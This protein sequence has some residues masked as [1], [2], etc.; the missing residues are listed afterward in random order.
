[1]PPKVET[2]LKHAFAGYEWKV[3]GQ[4]QVNGVEVYD[5]SV[6]NQFGQSTAAVTKHGDFL[7]SGV[8]N[9]PSRMAG[10]VKNAF[11]RLFKTPPTDVDRYTVTHYLVDLDTGGGQPERVVFDAVGRVRDIHTAAQL[12]HSEQTFAKEQDDTNPDR[13]RRVSDVIERVYGEK[14]P[15]IEHVYAMPN[16]ENFYDVEYKG[17]G[18]KTI[19]IVTNGNDVFSRRAEIPAEELPPSVKRTLD[20]MFKSD[21]VMSVFRKRFEYYQIDQP[22]PDGDMMTMRIAT[23]GLVMSV[24]S[25]KADQENM[26]AEQKHR[27]MKTGNKPAL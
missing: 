26:A 10:P 14:N 15:Q 19:A 1:M 8:P 7:L 22:T 11:E 2:A 3:V 27:A 20:A 5:V 18:G 17:P 13:R 16:V 6:Q 21:K 25:Q 9:D 4:R 23:D 12:K 24:S